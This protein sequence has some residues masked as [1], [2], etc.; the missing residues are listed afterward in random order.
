MVAASVANLNTYLN[1]TSKITYTTDSNDTTAATLTVTPN[2]G[3]VDGTADTVGISVTAV[4]DKPE[5]GGTPSDETATED[6]ARPS[7]SAYN[8]SDAEGDDL[9]LTLSVDR[10]PRPRAAGTGITITG[11]NTA[12]ITLAGTIANLNTYLDD[13]TKIEFKTTLNDTAAATLTVT[14]NDG[15]VD[16]YGGYGGHR[17]HARNDAPTLRLRG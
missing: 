16:G 10:V 13:T 3:T 14:P 11:S 6:Q 5:L 2:D 15:T 7:I 1:D 8:L 9:T 17:H 4:N 12:T